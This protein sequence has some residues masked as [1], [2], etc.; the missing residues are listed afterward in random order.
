MWNIF[1]KNKSK[2][3]EQRNLIISSM[4]P[5]SVADDLYKVAK[6]KLP[7][8]LPKGWG[9]SENAPESYNRYLGNDENQYYWWKDMSQKYTV[10][11]VGASE[12][13]L[14]RSE[15]P[16]KYTILPDWVERCEGFYP[17][18]WILKVKTLSNATINLVTYEA[19]PNASEPSFAKIVFSE[20]NI[21]FKQMKN[22]CAAV[23]KYNKEELQLHGMGVS[24]NYDMGED[25]RIRDKT[26]QFLP[27]AFSVENAID[28]LYMQYEDWRRFPDVEDY[29]TMVKL[30]FAWKHVEAMQN[31][32]HSGGIK[33]TIEKI[34]SDIKK[35]QAR[36]AKLEKEQNELYEKA[37]DALN[38]L[39][40][41]G[42]DLKK[43][44][45]IQNK[46]FMGK[47]TTQIDLA[48]LNKLAT[49][50]GLSPKS[51]DPY[52]ANTARYTLA[53]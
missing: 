28:D 17:T 34:R 14:K 30:S 41:Y 46:E 20:N 12:G 9:S 27:D 38:L 42:F 19:G 6:K 8:S 31:E 48:L 10:P 18:A 35:S 37:A 32:E 43:I 33:K 49:G 36:I 53:P 40:E 25:G 13:K 7:D 15:W 11:G 29:D 39:E 4:S 26:R 47:E 52:G 23:S 22:L 44:E 16:K 5:A 2:C 24:K 51:S 45:A 3:E 1:K 50:M 21:P